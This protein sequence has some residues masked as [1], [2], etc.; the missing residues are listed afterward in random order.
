MLHRSIAICALV[1]CGSVVAQSMNQAPPRLVKSEKLASYWTMINSSVQADVPNYGKNLQQPG[2]A[3]VSF[4]VEK[5]GNT[6]TAKVQR[7]VPEGDLTKVALSVVA[8]LHFEPTVFNA[9]R[10]RVFS[11]LI[12]PFNLPKDPSARTAVM[13]KCLVEHL[14]WNDR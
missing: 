5:D 2:C 8:N 9:G 1:C 10:E 3:T 6:S 12:F 11:W 7:V 4:V 14:G 13:Q